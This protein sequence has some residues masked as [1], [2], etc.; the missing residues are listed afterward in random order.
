MS[1]ISTPFSAPCAA[2]A[3]SSV[4]DYEGLP[5]TKNYYDTLGTVITPKA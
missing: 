5:A 1:A 2:R 3:V 4:I